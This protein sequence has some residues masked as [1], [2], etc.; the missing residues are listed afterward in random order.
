M[1]RS[2]LSARN[3]SNAFFTPARIEVLV[4]RKRRKSDYSLVDPSEFR[5]SW[6]I[7]ETRQPTE[8]IVNSPLQP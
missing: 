7:V 5:A 1:A 3:S 6:P 4:W 2:G 8:A